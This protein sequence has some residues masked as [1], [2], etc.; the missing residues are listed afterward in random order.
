MGVRR[1]ST[2]RAFLLAVPLVAGLLALFSLAS[3]NDLN[4]LATEQDPATTNTPATGTLDISTSPTTGAV[5]ADSSLGPAASLPADPA[6]TG[7]PQD[8]GA[9]PTTGAGPQTTLVANDPSGSS[10]DDSSTIGSSTAG[11]DTGGSS[12]TDSGSSE[13]TTSSLVELTLTSPPTVTG[14]TT[15]RSPT[16]ASPATASQDDGASGLNQTTV[17]ESAELDS[18]VADADSDDEP[19]TPSEILRAVVIAA[20]FVALIVLV[21]WALAKFAGLF[22]RGSDDEGTDDLSGDAL[23]ILAVNDAIDPV[24]ALDRLR[25][26]LEAEPDPR[27][28]IQRAY[29]VVESGFANPELA[30][31]KSETPTRYLER[32]LGRIEGSGN[33][34]AQLTNLFQF[35]RYS[36][37]P[38]TEDMRLAAI[39]SVLGLRSRYRLASQVS[40]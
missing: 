7:V 39:D 13:G 37:H 26:E 27:Q 28:A 40:V 17:L 10:S 34:L 38:V 2:G 11:S 15:L 32:C 8:S 12:T 9:L 25:H 20:G 4:S 14:Q 18:A 5:G 33:D 3:T 29:A 22:G 35:A 24:D 1:S 6:T 23:E 36:P 30:R 21:I 19:P 31:R 16:S